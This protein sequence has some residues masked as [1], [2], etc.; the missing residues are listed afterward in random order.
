MDAPP[1]PHSIPRDRSHDG[2]Q[3]GGRDNSTECVGAAQRGTRWIDRSSLEAGGQ[4]DFLAVSGWWSLLAIPTT[5]LAWRMPMNTRDLFTVA[6]AALVLRIPRVA[7]ERIAGVRSSLIEGV[8]GVAASRITSANAPS[9]M[10][11]VSPYTAPTSTISEPPSQRT[12]LRLKTWT[13][14][15]AVSA[16]V[17]RISWSQWCACRR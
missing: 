2:K 9:V 17:K 5:D 1:T 10:Y 4:A 7:L 15:V 13:R 8:E 12:P 16:P 14:P 6:E 11:L 3:D